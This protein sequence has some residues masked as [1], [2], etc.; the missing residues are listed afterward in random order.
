VTSRLVLRQQPGLDEL[1][2]LPVETLAA[3]L[4]ELSGH[5]L[6]DPFNN[7]RKLKRV[8]QESF[9]LPASLTLPLQRILELTLDHIRFLEGQVAQ[10]ESWIADEVCSCPPIAKLT[11]IPGVGPVFS[12]GIGSEVGKTQRFLQGTKWDKKRKKQRPRN[13]R[14]AEDAVAKLAGLWWPRAASGDFEAQDRH[15]AKSGNRYLRYYL[16]QAA[17]RMRKYI[18]Q[19]SAFYA[20]KYQQTAKHHHKRALVLTARKS[21][22]LFVGL[23]HRNESYRP[24]GA[25]EN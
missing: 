9:A 2:N 1:A 7:A 21:V 3:Q 22:G 8:A 12:A 14:D 6:P 18:P 15:M 25:S 23:L 4:H 16:I 10:V 24:G 5:H 19:Y 17:D 13:L 20:R 11:T